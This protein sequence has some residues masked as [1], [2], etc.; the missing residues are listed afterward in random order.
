MDDG[1]V[2]RVIAH[3]APALRRDY[4]VMEL[5]ANLLAEERK[6]LLTCF[7]APHFRKTAVVVMGEPSE[8]HKQVVRDEILSE[9]KAK[10]ETE[11]KRKAELAE[12]RRLLE[13]RKRKADE[14]RK[15]AQQ[16]KAGAQEAEDAKDEAAPQK[17]EEE[18][19]VA[20]PEPELTEEEQKQWFRKS[21]NPDISSAVLARTYASFTLPGE[22][23]G[24]DEIRYEWQAE[25]PCKAL[26]R[27]FVLEN[28]RT[29][30]VEDLQVSDWFK[31]HLSKWQKVLQD[32]RN[33]EREYKDPAK[34]RAAQ[35]RKLAELKKKEE[36]ENKE[37]NGDEKM[38]GKEENGDTASMEIN[39]EEVDVMSV[40]DVMDLG[41]GEP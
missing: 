35:Q 22:D 10:Q 23:E 14:A 30:R 19:E 20:L 1:S 9:K 3:I 36:E 25:Q 2:R 21:T 18:G 4:L 17:E 41:N 34:R 40:E 7:G 11:R 31:E 13:E 37:E 32:W 6:E 24:F 5:G 12:R 8:A 38:D 26:L 39:A 28:K 15:A 29:Q 16:K 33:K 27:D